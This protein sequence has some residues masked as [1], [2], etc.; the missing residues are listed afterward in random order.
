MPRMR[1]LIRRHGLFRADHPPRILDTICGLAGKPVSVGDFWEAHKM[2]VGKI[3]RNTAA[4]RF[5]FLVEL[6][7]VVETAVPHR[8]TLTEEGRRICDLRKFGSKDYH[9]RLG[10]LLLKGD[11]NEEF[12][13]FLKASSPFIARSQIT[14]IF[15]RQTSTLIEWCKEGALVKEESGMIIVR[16]QTDV[17]KSP[18]EFWKRLR[19]SF[20]SLSQ[21]SAPGATRMF[22][23]I[24]E[25]YQNI[26]GNLDWSE[27]NSFERFLTQTVEDP[28]YRPWIELAGAPPAYV[29]REVPRRFFYNHRNYY[30]MSIR[31]PEVKR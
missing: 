1:R 4:D 28:R 6:G 13:D 12:K 21:V 9:S 25:L 24:T 3:A 8:Y 19:S 30:F 26:V 15:K 20:R 5:Y 23:S 29:D 2:I 22:V 27:E 7:F 17:I 18:E 10:E 11:K 16:N 14:R 31:D